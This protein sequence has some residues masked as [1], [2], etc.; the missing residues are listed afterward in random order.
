MVENLETSAPLSAVRSLTRRMKKKNSKK[1]KAVSF[2]D[3]DED[4][5][6]DKIPQIK[7]KC[8]QYHG[9]CGHSMDECTTLKD[10]IKKAKSNKSK[11]HSKGG[12]KTYTKH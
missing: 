5:S 8:Y 2:E 4:S 9:R 3:S 6:D 7:K 1:R 10:L 11:G 12:K